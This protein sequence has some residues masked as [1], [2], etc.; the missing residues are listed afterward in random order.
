[1][2][3]PNLL[4]EDNIQIE[5]NK[6]FD[7]TRKDDLIFKE[8]VCSNF[9]A[10]IGLVNSVA[11]FAEKLD[12]HPE[13]NIYGWNKVRITLSS[14]D[15]GGLTNLDFNLAEKIDSIKIY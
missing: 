3:R 9:A 10:A 15:V 13:I 14:H 11:V 7:W 5:L 2:T 6:R 12:H 1:M 8:I 4:D